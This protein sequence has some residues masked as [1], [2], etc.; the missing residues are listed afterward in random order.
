MTHRLL[1]TLI[2]GLPPQSLTKTAVRGEYTDAELADMGR[3]QHDHGPWSHLEL[4]VAH[5]IDEVAWNSHILGAANGGKADKPK[6]YPRPGITPP[7][8]ARRG[9]LTPDQIAV[10]DAVNPR[11]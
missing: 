4:L 6:P 2:D 3:Q 8:G 7:G 5:L 11:G 1:Q 10:I 9:R